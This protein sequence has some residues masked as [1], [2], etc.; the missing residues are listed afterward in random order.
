MIMFSGAT[1]VKWGTVTL[2]TGSG[3]RYLHYCQVK[4]IGMVQM[5]IYGRVCA[6]VVG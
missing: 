6:C 1:H 4:R 3:A 5:Y 2:A